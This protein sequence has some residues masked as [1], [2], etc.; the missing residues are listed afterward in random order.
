MK[1]LFLA[2]LVAGALGAAPALAQ[3]YGAS[4]SMSGAAASKDKKSMTPDQMRAHCK[5]MMAKEKAGQTS[6]MSGKS[7]AD[8]KKMHDK[9]A[10]LMAQDKSATKP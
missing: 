9:C 5:D 8:M 2:A 6:S 4:S 10:A 1:S 7:P 3:D